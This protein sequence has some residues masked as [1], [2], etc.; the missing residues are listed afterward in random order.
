MFAD[1]LDG[2]GGNDTLDGGDG[3]DQLSG[4][5][6]ADNDQMTGGAGYDSFRAEL[7]WN[8]TDYEGFGADVVTDFSEGDMLEVI[9][10]GGP[11][12]TL[13]VS[14]TAT[15]TVLTFGA[16]TPY[17]S[18]L[19]LQNYIVPEWDLPFDGQ[20][21]GSLMLHGSIGGI[22]SDDHIIGLAGVDDILSGGAGN[23]TL[24]GLSGN[25]SLYGDAGD[26]L[27]LGGE[28]DDHLYAFEDADTLEGGAGNDT[29]FADLGDEVLSGGS[30]M[31]RFE[32]GAVYDPVSGMDVGF[33]NDTITDFGEG[34]T[35]SLSAW[36]GATV[37]ASHVGTDT[38]LT[39]WA[40]TSQ[41][42][43]VT[44]QNYFVDPAELPSDGIILAGDWTLWG[45]GFAQ[46]SDD[47]IV[48]GPG[49]SSWLYG[50]GGNDT[51]FGEDMNDWLYG[52]TGADSLEGGDGSDVLYGEDG[53]D[54]LT[55]G[56]GFDQ[57]G[58]DVFTG[59][60]PGEAVGFGND[61][62]TDFGDGDWLQLSSFGATDTTISLN[63][64]GSD[65]ILTF[66]AGT[67]HESTI[68][69]QN[70]VMDSWDLPPSGS[71]SGG[72][73]IY[74]YAYGVATDDYV[75]GAAGMM[76]HLDGY[77]GNDTL[78]AGDMGDYL[79]GGL[80]DDSLVGGIGSDQIHGD[81][82]D[83]TILGGDGDDTIYASLE[84]DS[85][86]ITGGAGL[87]RVHFELHSDYLTG[88]GIGFGH[89]TVTD[90]ADGDVLELETYLGSPVSID[91]V[92]SGSD[93]ILTFGAGTD[94][95]STITLQNYVMDSWDLPPSGSFS[96][97]LG[98]YGYAYGVATDDY[99]VGAAGM[100]NH[101]DGYAG[102][103]TLIAGDMGDYLFGGLGDD[104][105]V[106][107]IGSD[108]IYGDFG[109]DT[110]LGGDGDDTIYASLE[111]DNDL[112]TG[113]AG[114]DRVHFDLHSD[115]LTGAGVGFGH[116][117]VT[118]FADGDVLEL[119]NYLGSPV[120]ID[121]VITG[122]DTILTF[123]A[124]TDHES[125]ITLQ[126]YHMMPWDL[127]SHDLSSD[128][129]VMGYSYNIYSDDLLTG[130]AGVA[131]VLDGGAGNDTLT[132]FGGGDDLYGGTGD[133][134]LSADDVAIGDGG[135]WLFGDQG[136]DS[137]TGGD[138]SDHLVGGE[139]DDLL[140][141]GTGADH[142]QF[143]IYTDG[144]DTFD[145]GSDLVTDLEVGDTLEIMGWGLGSLSVSVTQIGTDTLITAEAGTGHESSILLQDV[146][147]STRDWSLSGETFMLWG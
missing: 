127:P 107:G 109:D 91:L 47:L 51:L 103:D 10:F 128:L 83:D 89:D 76:N 15:D 79:F 143:E 110:I 106:G 85:D 87:D 70:Y 19:T 24:E 115:Y 37:S 138:G 4:G 101:L 23:D 46:V 29:L 140:T 142:F 62:V 119:E 56:A 131:D 1:T 77:A 95:E 68:T 134:V 72:L 48:D 73:G 22:V 125:T 41:E 39:F 78:I 132:G 112:I 58:F 141:G 16:G 136:N 84:A 57:F 117:T 36:S 116:D 55:G 44:L 96:G 35:L 27:I 123:G 94:H 118:D 81:F 144:S 64:V 45:Y 105:L 34:D 2:A 13:S 31:D 43:T 9:S 75:V 111:A 99:V 50:E 18:S 54:V 53:D 5:Y 108:Q 146:L 98:I 126:N 135:N 120:S 97:G 93:T 90:F 139:G 61:T 11:A 42:S 86:L 7:V 17:E 8:G 3:D 33:G 121:L 122:S 102:N 100:M 65:T 28:G 71:F 137:L 113:G 52:G 133:D 59:Y 14:Y 69:L 130:S 147:V 60:A 145:F 124:G 92:I 20:V 12:V 129:S 32:L 38:V 49:L 25:D 26:D 40:G 74:G 30:G 6:G 21:T 66:G 114:L 104:S 67:D 63:H 88:A 80:G 82:G